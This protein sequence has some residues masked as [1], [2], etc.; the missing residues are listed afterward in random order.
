MQCHYVTKRYITTCVSYCHVIMLAIVFLYWNFLMIHPQSCERGFPHCAHGV[1]PSVVRTGVSALRRTGLLTCICLYVRINVAV[2]SVGYTWSVFMHFVHSAL[3]HQARP[4]V[5][6]SRPFMPSSRPSAC[7][8]SKWQGVT[9][10][11]KHSK[12]SCFCHCSCVVCSE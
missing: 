6:P 11:H 4:F 12:W 3:C 7:A 1:L 2:V 8:V 9:W 5:P 10:K